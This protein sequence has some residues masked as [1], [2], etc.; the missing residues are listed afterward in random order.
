MARTVAA[1]IGTNLAMPL[2]DTGTIALILSTTAIVAPKVMSIISHHRAV[3]RKEDLNSL[4]HQ[5]KEN[6]VLL[7]QYKEDNKDLRTRYSQL[8]KKCR[9]LDDRVDLLERLLMKNNIEPPPWAFRS[10]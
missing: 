1:S 4:I 3:Q 9:I 2:P 10:D 5:S 7:D 6:K 8:E